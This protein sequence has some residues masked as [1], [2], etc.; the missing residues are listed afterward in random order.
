MLVVA[1]AVRNVRSRKN[2][3][4][5]IT[6]LN[7]SEYQLSKCVRSTTRK[8]GLD[9]LCHVLLGDF[10][11]IPAEDQSFDAVYHIEA[12]AH[13]PRQRSRSTRRSFEF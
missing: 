13:A 11:A 9:D 10:M 1:L 3:V 8:S 12:I 7:I 4:P 2:T 6:G 5:T